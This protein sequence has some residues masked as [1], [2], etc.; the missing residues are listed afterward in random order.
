MSWTISLRRGGLIGTVPSRHDRRRRKS[1]HSPAVHASSE[2]QSDIPLAQR[3]WRLSDA[4]PAEKAAPMNALLLIRSHMATVY[5]LGVVFL[6][7]VALSALKLSIPDVIPGAELLVFGWLGVVL[8]RLAV[9]AGADPVAAPKPE[10]AEKSDRLDAI[11][12]AIVRL[13]QAQATES[14]AFSERLKGAN[15]RLAQHTDATSVRDIVLA[16]IEDNRHMR[17]KLS[18]VRDQ[19]EES[20]L[21][22]VQLQSVLERSEEAGM[23]DVVTLI[24]NRRYFDATIAQE[25][26]RARRTGESFCLTLADIDRFK[27][28][29]DRFGHLVGDRVLRLF[30]EILVQNVRGQDRVARFGGEEFALMMSGASLEDATAAAERIRTVLETKQWALGPTGGPVGPITASFGIAGLRAG[31]TGDDLIR[32]ADGR[33][34]EAKGQGRNCVV[35]DPPDS[36]RTPRRAQR[37]KRV[38]NG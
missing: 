36:P 38:A 32:R 17:D 31:E 4:L 26:E 27:L 37:S 14:E 28:V 3:V 18:K 15:T 10:A 22:V 1:V 9:G 23:R 16:L 25:L 21:Q 29:N 35:V 2:E 33:L 6:V 34:Y 24:G 5:A 20:K 19:L 7:A 12:R 13:L 11:V 30:A 8:G